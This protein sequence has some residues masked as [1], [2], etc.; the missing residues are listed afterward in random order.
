MGYLFG[1][2]LSRRLGLSMGVDLLK[3]KT[4]NLD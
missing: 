3:Y 1:P 2:V 4:C